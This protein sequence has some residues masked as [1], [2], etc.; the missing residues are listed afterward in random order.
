MELRMVRVPIVG[1]EKCAKLY[2]GFNNISQAMICAGQDLGQKD[3]CQVR[4]SF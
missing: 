4:F 3:A 2:N 1:R